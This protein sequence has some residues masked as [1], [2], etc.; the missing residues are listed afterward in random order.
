MHKCFFII[1]FFKCLLIQAQVPFADYQ[2]PFPQSYLGMAN[3][4]FNELMADKSNIYIY[5][6]VSFPSFQNKPMVFRKNGSFDYTLYGSNAQTRI[7]NTVFNEKL[8]SY[9]L[10]VSTDAT[11]GCSSGGLKISKLNKGSLSLEDSAFFCDPL[12]AAAG[13]GCFAHNRF[14]VAG[15]FAEYYPPPMPITYH[16]YRNL[17]RRIDTN[18]VMIDEKLIGDTSTIFWTYFLREAVDTGIVLNAINETD[19]CPMLMKLDTLGSELWR[20]KYYPYSQSGCGN[21]SGTGIMGMQSYQNGYIAL[22]DLGFGCSQ[23]FYSQSILAKIGKNGNL[24]KEVQ[25][26]TTGD[27]TLDFHSSFT[28][29]TKRTKF[30]NILVKT[31]DGN[32]ASVICDRERYGFLNHE[33]YIVILDTNLNII[34]R[35]P[36]LGSLA[37]FD[38]PGLVQGSD[39][40]LYLGGGVMNST[41]DGMNVRIYSY[42]VGG[43]VGI[44]EYGNEPEIKLYP[45]P[46][47][48]ELTVE[49]FDSDQHVTIYNN[50]GQLVYSQMQ[51]GTFKVNVSVWAKGLYL[52]EL[53]DSEK[54][55]KQTQK[56][57]VE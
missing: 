37:G 56:F 49:A 14:Y 25:Y 24:V 17:I 38:N 36:K 45:N 28:N 12:K 30:Y 46:V 19:G 11:A 22:F 55:S 8:K 33:N 48:N 39:S 34:H 23:N 21:G 47:V 20:K 29:Y 13:L 6:Y 44:I 2:N 52:I 4:T 31:N 43:Q 3:G 5:G 26:T 32:F 18:L 27:T 1:L 40:T 7:W 50:M 57:I 53:N 41:N 10:F 16:K 51:N 54:H 15:A 35:S 42:K 9:Y